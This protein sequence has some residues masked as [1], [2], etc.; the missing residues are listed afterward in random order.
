MKK[1][2]AARLCLLVAVLLA[3]LVPGCRDDD[4]SKQIPGPNQSDIN[5]FELYRM[6]AFGI[7]PNRLPSD[8]IARTKRILGYDERY[9]RLTENFGYEWSHANIMRIQSVESKRVTYLVKGDQYLRLN[10]PEG[11]EFISEILEEYTF[12]K[13][14]FRDPYK[15]E[16]FLRV[17][18]KFYGDVY[19]IVA[20][21]AFWRH[22]EAE[23]PPFWWSEGTEKSKEVFRN[24]CFDPSFEFNGNKWEITFNTITRHGGAE[25]WK[26]WGQFDPERDINRI[27]HIEI[28]TLKKDGSFFWPYVG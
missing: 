17:L 12:R 11:I 3:I 28:T 7:E 15:T 6:M 22:A 20:T 1:V 4:G 21:E 9:W 2:K 16:I 13:D 14:D 24:L 26:V 25:Q 5:D 23:P 8:L 18:T 10:C 19:G 27:T